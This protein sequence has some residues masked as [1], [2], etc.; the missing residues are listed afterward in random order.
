MTRLKKILVVDDEV[1]IRNILFD[2][3]SSEGFKVTVAKDGMDS[4]DQMQKRR[5][6]LLITDINMPRL[7]GIAL[8]RKMKEAGRKE[9]VIIMT[10][11]PVDRSLLVED[12]PPVFT[13]LEKPFQINNFLAAVTLALARPAKNDSKRV[14]AG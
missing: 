9:K 5:F 8:L 14:G 13:Q 1:G 4:L 12:I 2:A 11:K 7:D 6:D 3:L 10:G